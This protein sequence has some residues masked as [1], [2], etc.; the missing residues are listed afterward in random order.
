M[1]KTFIKIFFNLIGIISLIL[2]IIG[3][4]LPL[5]PTTPFLL[6]ALFCFTKSSKRMAKFFIKSKIYKNYLYPFVKSKGLPLNKKIQILIIVLIMLLVPF[7]MSQNIYVKII[8]IFLIFL[9]I[10]IF[11]FK[12]KTI[13]NFDNKIEKT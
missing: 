9:K 4:V 11:I 8:I 12:I 1:A 10:Y 2:G 3:I 6:L 5:L 13:K 7:F